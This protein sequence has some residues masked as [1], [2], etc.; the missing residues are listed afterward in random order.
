[1]KTSILY[2]IMALVLG[3]LGVEGYILYNNYQDRNV[4]DNGSIKDKDLNNDKDKSDDEQKNSEENNDL[5]ENNEKMEDGVKLLNTT[6][7]NDK[8]VQEY[9]IVLNGN[10]NIIDID[11]KIATYDTGYE[12]PYYC[13]DSLYYSNCSD[14]YSSPDNLSSQYINSKFNEK[15]F[16]IIK[17]LDNKNYLAIHSFNLNIDKPD[18]VYLDTSSYT[19]HI[20]NDNLQEIKPT[21]NLYNHLGIK[22]QN[23]NDW[24]G[25]IGAVDI[26]S[27]CLDYE[28]NN[29]GDFW[30]SSKFNIDNNQIRVK[31]ENNKIYSLVYF[32]DSNVSCD[33]GT[34]EERE[35]S[36]N[37]NSFSY[38]VL[39]TYKTK[40]AVGWC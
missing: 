30:Y 13:I 19:I 4:V 14:E 8:I 17:G 5:E 37:N 27:L 23:I 36:I 18:S 34:I 33:D 15:N 6:K 12:D 25:F 3:V 26:Q 32:S 10:K 22:L 9:E 39:N 1:M 24:N 35:Y 38:R 16:E 28:C 2:V 21:E 7:E 20:L 29:M 40:N 11:Y 31:I